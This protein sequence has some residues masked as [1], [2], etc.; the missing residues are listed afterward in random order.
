ML[1]RFRVL[2][3]LLLA[4][5]FLS[6][7]G[8]TECDQPITFRAIPWGSSL[9]D[10]LEMLADEGIVMPDPKAVD[11][12]VE[13]C[14]CGEHMAFHTYQ[15][16]LDT[17]I[18]VAGDDVQQVSLYAL[19]GIM[20]D[21]TISP[22]ADDSHLYR[23]TYMYG[24]WDYDTEAE[25]A[26]NVYGDLAIKLATLY[27]AGEASHDETVSGGVVFVDNDATVWRGSDNTA[28]V[29]SLNR[30][31]SK[32]RVYINYWDTTCCDMF[33]ALAAAAPELSGL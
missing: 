1:H 18:T 32:V 3:C 14:F 19:A 28:V 2:L 5:L 8:L 10:A 22:S 23:C 15:S 13:E 17:P 20:D 33:M 21:G 29:L 7:V 27:G 11:K 26:R 6:S 12:L 24:S 31:F 16:S 30:T 9:P 4:V 25:A